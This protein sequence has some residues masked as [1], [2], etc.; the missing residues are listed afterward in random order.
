MTASA[1]TSTLPQARGLTI[2]KLIMNIHILLESLL[3]G[4]LIASGIELV[5]VFRLLKRSMGLNQEL[6]DLIQK[7]QKLVASIKTDD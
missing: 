1:R 4:A 6:I 7:L 3:A 2:K 5:R